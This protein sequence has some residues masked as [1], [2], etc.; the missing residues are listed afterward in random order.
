MP[1]NIMPSQPEYPGQNYSTHNQPAAAS[2]SLPV[3][4]NSVPMP[5]DEPMPVV[6]VLSVRGV[7]YAMMTIVLWFSAATLGW[8][9]LNAVNGSANFNYLVVPLSGLLVSLPI[10]ALLF[11]RLKRAE[12][13]TPSLKLEPSKRRFSQLTQII[14]F[15]VVLINLSV[16]VYDILKKLASHPA[17][18]LTK[19]SLNLVIVSGIAGGI[20][21]YY[22]FDE[23]RN[24]K[25]K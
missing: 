20:L 2:P 9:L 8:L 7:E 11:I 25:R 4:D 3:V 16:F 22:W 18:S 21:L 23:H 17:T 6:K 12:L 5:S 13:A 14:A 15:L 10:F 19:A 24:F 1:P